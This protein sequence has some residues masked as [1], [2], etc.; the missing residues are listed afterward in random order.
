MKNKQG[1]STLPRPSTVGGGG[2]AVAQLRNRNA[3]GWDFPPLS[4]HKHKPLW[5]SDPP[6]PIYCHYAYQYLPNYIIYVWISAYDIFIYVRDSNYGIFWLF[7][8]L[9]SCHSNGVHRE[10]PNVRS[11]NET[12]IF[13]GCARS[14]DN[15]NARSANEGEFY[16]PILWQFIFSLSLRGKVPKNL[17]T[18]NAETSFELQSLSLR[19]ALIRCLKWKWR[20][21]KSITSMDHSR[22]LVFCRNLG[23]LCPQVQETLMKRALPLSWLT[24][25][26]KLI[27]LC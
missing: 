18:L 8:P 20:K 26:P 12:S 13:G 11:T 15:A 2:V 22:S 19:Q 6:A 16:R 14:R 24:F 27:P 4:T 1:L 9:L 25:Y 5:S 21:V 17:H 23:K 10:S 7:E 3:R